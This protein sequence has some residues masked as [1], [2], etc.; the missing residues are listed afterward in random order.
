[1]CVWEILILSIIIVI[2]C[3]LLSS[4]LLNIIKIE[5]HVSQKTEK[6][7]NMCLGDFC[8][9]LNFFWEIETK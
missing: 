2:N 4:L 7:E 9:E 3:L 6:E 1:M 5:R 8:W